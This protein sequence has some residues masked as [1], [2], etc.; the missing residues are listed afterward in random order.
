MAS[1]LS[2]HHKVQH[3]SACILNTSACNDWFLVLMCGYVT[4]MTL[5]FLTTEEG[6]FR[7]QPRNDSCE[8]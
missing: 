1:F 8:L 5:A 4:H 2:H 7:Y 6:S 3:W